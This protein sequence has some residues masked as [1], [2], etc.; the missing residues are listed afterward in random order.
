MAMVLESSFLSLVILVTITTFLLAFLSY[1]FTKAFFYELARVSKQ[2]YFHLCFLDFF[3][4][5]CTIFFFGLGALFILASFILQLIGWIHFKEFAQE[6]EESQN[7]TSNLLVNAN[8][9]LIKTL[10]IISFALRLL[11]HYIIQIFCL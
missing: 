9:E 3:I 11:L 8:L 7:E 4:G 2:K 10:M 5:F 6:N 1:K